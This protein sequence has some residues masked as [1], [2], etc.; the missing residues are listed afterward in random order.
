MDNVDICMITLLVCL[1]VYWTM[2][3]KINCG[4]KLK[5]VERK[6]LPKELISRKKMTYDRLALSQHLKDVSQQL[7][8]SPK[9]LIAREFRFQGNFNSDLKAYTEMDSKKKDADKMDR[10][11]ETS[12]RSE[13]NSWRRL[14]RMNEDE[15]KMNRFKETTPRSDHDSWRRRR[16]MNEDEDK[17]NRFKETTFSTPRSDHDSLRGRR[18]MNEDEDKM[19]RFKETTPRSDHDSWRRRRRMNEDEDKMNRFKETTPR[20][21]HDSRRRRRRMNEDED[22]MNRFK[23]TTPRTDHDSRRRRRRMNEGSKN[24]DQTKTQKRPTS[25]DAENA[26]PSEE[27]GFTWIGG[28]DYQTTILTSPTKPE[29]KRWCYAQE[30][31]KPSLTVLDVREEQ[32]AYPVAWLPPPPPDPPNPP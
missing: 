30:A 12:P 5:G 22:K 19:N 8:S 29:E 28:T 16:R 3:F 13:Y 2:W 17:M 32:E 24:E 7:A 21:D 11:K 6:D 26:D 18:R 27:R 20:S 15:D 25:I 1:L 10:I 23:E 14:A 9:P 31:M 4:R